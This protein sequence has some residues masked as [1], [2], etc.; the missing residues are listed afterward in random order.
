MGRA[1]EM[2]STQKP[3]GRVSIYLCMQGLVS[4]KQAGRFTASSACRNKPLRSLMETVPSPSLYFFPF[5]RMSTCWPAKAHIGLSEKMDPVL[6]Y[7]DKIMAS[8]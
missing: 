5:F 4:H 6:K 1:H 3:V 2:K 8:D 7:L